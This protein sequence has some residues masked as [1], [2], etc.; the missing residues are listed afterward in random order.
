MT[1]PAYTHYMLIVDRSGSM[2]VIREETEQGIA[3]FVSE[4]RALLLDGQRATLSLYQFDNEHEAV[5]QFTPLADIVPY[6]L[7][8]RNL[9]ALLDA[10]GFAITDE[11]AG[12]AA[13]PEQERPGKVLVLIATDGVENASQ[14][15]TK[16]RIKALIE[17]QRDRYGWQV[18]YIGANHDAF[19]EAGGMGITTRST[20]GYS[21][22][23]RGTRTAW[24]NSTAAATRYVKGAAGDFSYSDEEQ[25]SAEGPAGQTG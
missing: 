8:P 11:G 19:A 2:A 23:S 18:A 9:T 17:E 14:E 13:M 3:S 16:P 10:V 12:L 21:G 24:G 25:G 6:V 5:C 20:S 1:D 22:D 15:W 7:A 4:Q